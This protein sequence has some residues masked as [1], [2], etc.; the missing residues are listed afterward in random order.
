MSSYARHRPEESVL[1]QSVAR[2]WPKIEIEYAI[3]D[4]SIS[5]HVTAEFA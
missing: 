5:P 1:Y 3:A 2:A 4:Q